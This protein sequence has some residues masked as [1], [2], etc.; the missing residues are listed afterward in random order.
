M[1]AKK[2]DTSVLYSLNHD[3]SQELISE[4]VKETCRKHMAFSKR[5]GDRQFWASL[6]W[7]MDLDER[8]MAQEQED[9]NL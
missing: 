4:S 3:I 6:E 9:C 1:K 5:V 2:I 7:S 8:K